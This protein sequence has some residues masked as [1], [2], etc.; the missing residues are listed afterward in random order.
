LTINPVLSAFIYLQRFKPHLMFMPS[1]EFVIMHV[2]P[3]S[4]AIAP[5]QHQR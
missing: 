2:D 3:H 4:G 1:N 5:A